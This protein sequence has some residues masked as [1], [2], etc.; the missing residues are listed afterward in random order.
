M[1]VK[2]HLQLIFSHLKTILHFSSS[3]SVLKLV[4]LQQKNQLPSFLCINVSLQHIWLSP[5][6]LG[7]GKKI[8]IVQIV[9]SRWHL[10]GLICNAETSVHDFLSP[11]WQLFISG[12][13][14]EQGRKIIELQVC[15]ESRWKKAA[16]FRLSNLKHITLLCILTLLLMLKIT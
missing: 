13:I 2:G 6:N 15:G 8:Q 14:L 1:Q 12:K 9:L 4:S 16:F 10:Q 5:R 7:S 3:I 11:S